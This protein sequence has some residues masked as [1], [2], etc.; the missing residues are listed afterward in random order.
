RWDLRGARRAD[1]YLANSTVTQ[2]A[3]AEAYGIEAEVLPPPP[4]L[5]PTGPERAVGSLEPGFLL[6]VARLLPYKNVD[7]IIEA[8]NSLSDVR[9]VVVGAGPDW[10][11]LNA[12]AGP[13][14]SLL[15]CVDDEELRWLYRNSVGLVAAS[16]EDYGLS[17]LEAGTFGKPS[18]V[19][20][21]GGYLDTVVE[22]LNGG[23]FDSPTPAAIAEG[24]RDLRS[25][26]W[27]VAAIVDH[28]DRFSSQRFI[29]RLHEVVSQF[30]GTPVA[31]PTQRTP[32]AAVELVA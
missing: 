31:V 4:A 25:T 32:A 1:V 12:I 3:I 15:G 19:L 17:P 14:V 20:R 13:R 18:L 16:Y 9:L 28:V 27:D 10:D 29:R 22:G 24:I 2:R 5:M 8:V 11:R 30:V 7:V 23:F 26:S 21:A 6:C